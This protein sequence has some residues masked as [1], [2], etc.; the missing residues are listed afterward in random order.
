MLQS[1]FTRPGR[2]STGCRIHF[3]YVG[4][5]DVG[6]YDKQKRFQ[7]NSYVVFRHDASDIDPL[8]EDSEVPSVESE[9]EVGCGVNLL[10]SH[11]V[12]DPNFRQL[13]HEIHDHIDAVFANGEL[14]YEAHV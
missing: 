10:V 7:A 12:N 8:V 2:G 3:G 6:V 13:V 14:C 5:D 4:Y 1:S 9:V 11:Y